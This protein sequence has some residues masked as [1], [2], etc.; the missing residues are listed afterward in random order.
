MTNNKCISSFVSAAAPKKTPKCSAGYEVKGVK[1]Q[2]CYHVE[3][4]LLPGDTETTKVD[5]LVFGQ[6]VKMYNDNE[7]K[8]TMTWCM[9]LGFSVCVSLMKNS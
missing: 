3:Y 2:C 7:I 5:L 1:A 6:G 4:K 8:V 9:C